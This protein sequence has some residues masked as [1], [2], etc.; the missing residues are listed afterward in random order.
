MATTSAAAEATAEAG[1]GAGRDADIAS[2]LGL[3]GGSLHDAVR[4]SR[5]L[6]VGAGGIGCELLKN[7]VL[8]GFKDIQVVDLDTI[9]LSNLNRQFLFQNKHIKKPKATVARE[10]ALQFNPSVN[11]QAHHA[12]I[13]DAAFDL[14]WFKSFHLVLNALDNVAAR[15]HVNAMCIAADVPLIE[16]GTAGYL[17]QVMLHKRGLS[18]CY[19]CHPQPVERKTYAV[20]T[21]RSTPSE[22]IHCIV[23]AKNYLYNTLLGSPEDQDD[24]M[25]ENATPDNAKEIAELKLEADALKQLR[26]N[27]GNKDYG[28]MVFVKDIHRLLG[29]EDMWKTRTR[30]TVL[31][32]EKLV[33]QSADLEPM[34]PNS[35]DFDQKVWETSHNLHVFLTSLQ[36]LSKRLIK[37]R[38]KD[39]GYALSFDKDDEASLNFVTAAANLR[40]K[41]FHIP[42]KSRFEVK[43]MAGNIIPAIATTNAIVAGLIVMLAFKVLSG[44]YKSCTDTFVQYGGGRAHI[45]SN[46]APAEPNPQ[47]S[48]C[49]V[50]YFTLRIN[51]RTAKLSD[52]IDLVVKGGVF[53]AGTETDGLGLGGNITVNRDSGDKEALIHDEDF[54]DNLEL[55]LDAIGVKNGTKLNITNDVDD[56]DDGILPVAVRLFVEH[57][58]AA[59]GTQFELVGGDRKIKPRPVL[60]T[61]EQHPAASDAAAVASTSDGRV[62]KRANEDAPAESSHKRS[63][64]EETDI[65]AI[66]DDDENDQVL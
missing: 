32:F 62:L 24:A 6:M 19:D 10:S 37:E 63:R 47:C 55:T 51:T 52:L 57:W 54:D 48:V 35:L 13:F 15:R 4:S 26:E 38:K 61:V 41:T 45:L 27:I 18:P 33:A 36:T 60:K 30:P 23:W 12:S 9:D 28:T 1:A 59:T 50:G 11:I 29:M 64:V 46:E 56:G 2:V 58:D 39:A 44:D 16:S 65:I 7:L 42:C 25:N 5:V 3:L 17:G 8:S 66:D 49:T 43:Q 34:D 20:C 14:N 53:G 40:A 31:D 22:P 21:I